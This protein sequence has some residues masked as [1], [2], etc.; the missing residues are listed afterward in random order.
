MTTAV[1]LAGISAILAAGSYLYY[2]HKAKERPQ[3]EP[4]WEAALLG[5]P[6]GEGGVAVAARVSLRLPSLTLTSL[7]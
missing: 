2:V 7:P 6:D 1:S 3:P 5:V 4:D